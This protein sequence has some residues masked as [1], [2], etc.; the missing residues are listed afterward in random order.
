MEKKSPMYLGQ[1]T[2]HKWSEPLEVTVTE[3]ENESNESRTSMP[4]PPVWVS[5][6]S[7]GWKGEERD[8]ISS[9]F[10]LKLGGTSCRSKTRD[11]AHVHIKSLI[12]DQT[13]IWSASPAF[14]YCIYSGVYSLQSN[15]QMSWPAHNLPAT[16]C[17]MDTVVKTQHCIT[18][19]IFLSYVAY[20]MPFCFQTFSRML[21]EVCCT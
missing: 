5:G 17:W 7:R 4:Q 12:S 13:S 21:T 18:C 15:R 16:H 11:R 14:I 20:I 1:C 8:C 19:C 2:G 10:L 9:L 3:K 6:S